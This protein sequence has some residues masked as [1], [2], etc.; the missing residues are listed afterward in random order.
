MGMSS[1]DFLK[2]ITPSWKLLSVYQYNRLI[3]YG[4]NTVKNYTEISEEETTNPDNR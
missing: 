3:G 4:I 1:V 2:I